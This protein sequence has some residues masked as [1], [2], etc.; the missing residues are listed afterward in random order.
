MVNQQVFQIRF[1]VLPRFW[2]VKMNNT[3]LIPAFRAVWRAVPAVVQ[4]GNTLAEKIIY[5]RLVKVANVR[6]ILLTK[7]HKVPDKVALAQPF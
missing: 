7:G 4:P 1:F 3:P 2:A 5:Q 6:F